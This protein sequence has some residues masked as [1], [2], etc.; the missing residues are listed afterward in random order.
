MIQHEKSQSVR[1]VAVFSVVMLVFSVSAAPA[2][3]NENQDETLPIV[4]VAP[5]YPERAVQEKI[6][7]HVLL[8]FVVA[9][10]GAV[11]DA[12]VVD[13]NPPGVFD[14]A[15]LDAVGKFKYKPRIV[16]GKPVAVSGV[17]NRFSFEFEDESATDSTSQTA[18][19]DE[20]LPIVKV[21]PVYPDEAVREGIEGHVLLEFVV[22]ES[23]AVRD[24]VVLEAEPPGVFDQAALDAVGKFKYKP[25]V[26]DGEP[27]EITGVRNRFTFEFSDE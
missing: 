19:R 1:I 15:A 18:V 12:V 27:V 7:G 8:E 4:K 13:S 21:A 5:I 2:P 24:P 20:T 14:Q 26:V 3:A 23:G 16:D 6:E 22:T 25:K 11:R 9:E 10:T 17:R